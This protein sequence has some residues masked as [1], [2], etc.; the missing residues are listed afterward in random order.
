MDLIYS[1]NRISTVAITDYRMVSPVLAKVVLA[2]TGAPKADDVRKT[3][4]SG[5]KN[6]GNLVESSFRQIA[7]DAAVG[8]VRHQPAIEPFDEKVIR[9]H[10]KVMGSSKNIMMDTRDR[11]L[12]QIKEGPGGKFLACTGHEQLAELIEAQVSHERNN[13][14]SLRRITLASAQPGEFAAWVSQ[15]GDM[16]YGYVTRADDRRFEAFSITARTCTTQKNDVAVSFHNVPVLAKHH[17]AVVAALGAERGKD[18]AAYYREMLK[19]WDETGVPDGDGN[20]RSYTDKIVDQIG[21][22]TPLGL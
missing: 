12:W 4:A 22:D 20:Y 14:P 6:R 18:A 21:S 16:D 8:F 15:T 11:T 17:R 7:E 13:V 19:Q 9:A 2:W 1:N 3:V 5:L 10:Y